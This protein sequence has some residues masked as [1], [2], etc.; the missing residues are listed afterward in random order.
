MLLRRSAGQEQCGPGGVLGEIRHRLSGRIAAAHHAAQPL[1]HVRACTEVQDRRGRPPPNARTQPRLAVGRLR[2]GD[3]NRPA[4]NDLPVVE[5]E[6]VDAVLTSDRADLDRGDELCPEFQGLE[7]APMA[8][9]PRSIQPE[10]P[11]S[12]RFVGGSRLATQAKRIGTIE[13]NPSEARRRPG[14]GRPGRLRQ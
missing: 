6:P 13:A 12:S 14:P 11:C 10:I 8:G 3:Q 2:G 7:I 4:P 9:S 1:R 5:D